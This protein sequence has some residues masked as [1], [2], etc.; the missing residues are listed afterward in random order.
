MADF[1]YPSSAALKEIEQVKLPVLTQADPIFSILPVVE[2]DAHILMWD[3]EDTWTGLQQLRGLG[4][5]PGEVQRVGTGRYLV[6]P[7]IYGERTTIDEIELTAGRAA[8]TFSQPININRLVMRDQDRLL[9][10]RLNRIKQIGWALVTTGTYSVSGPSGIVHTDSYTLQTHSGSDWS[11]V[12]TATPLTDFRA[13]Q[14]KSRGKGVSF[15]ADATA[16]MNRVTFNRMLS[17][18]NANDLAGKRT[19]G[20]STVLSLADVNVIHAGEGLPQ[21]VVHDDGYVNDGGTFVPWIADD[22]VTVIGRRTNGAPLGDYCMTRNANNPNAAPGSYTKVDDDPKRVPRSLFV[23][24]GHNG[25]PR[26]YFP[27]AIVVMSV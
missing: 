4:G 20:L 12:A 27:S 1:V 8:G 19:S 18:T 26:V 17:N 5:A 7:G 24:D 23:H 2:E 16:Y 10:R 21:I 9:E 11:T 22:V 6:T 15:G 14:L 13:V 25:G 3:Q